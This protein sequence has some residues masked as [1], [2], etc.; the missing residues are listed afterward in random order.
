MKLFP[1]LVAALESR[2]PTW[3][4]FTFGDKNGYYSNEAEKADVFL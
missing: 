4:G 1:I 2:C 3:L